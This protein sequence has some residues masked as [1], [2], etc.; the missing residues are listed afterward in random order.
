MSAGLPTWWS[1]LPILFI[2]PIFHLE[3]VRDMWWPLYFA[4]PILFLLVNIP[5]ARGSARIR[6]WLLI[7]LLILQVLNWLW[8]FSFFSFSLGYH[9]VD[10]TLAVS[11]INAGLL[12]ALSGL[13][14]ANHRRQRFLI[15]LLFHWLAWAWITVYL[16][17]YLGELP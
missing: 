6:H 11:F 2:V 10:Y 9:G 5:L 3:L 4:T 15:S 8:I 7:P 14:F 12:L 1:P 16:F 13:W 17:P